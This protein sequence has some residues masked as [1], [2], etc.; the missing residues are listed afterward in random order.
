M[1]MMKVFS[2]SETLALTLQT[3]LEEAGVDTIV[4]NNVQTAKVSGAGA[5]GL[6]VEVFINEAYFAK[7]NPVIEAFR[8]SLG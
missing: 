7:A 4:K 6:A 5:K 8:M 2:G 1:G 3:K